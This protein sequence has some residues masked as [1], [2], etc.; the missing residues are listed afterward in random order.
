MELYNL[1][2]DSSEQYNLAKTH[3]ARTNELLELLEGW[4]NE[5]GAPVPTQLNPD[6]DP[7]TAPQF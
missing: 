3:P 5:T 7:K 6:Y 1:V 4:R 2:Q